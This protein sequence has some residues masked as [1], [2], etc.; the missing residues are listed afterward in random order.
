MANWSVESCSVC[1]DECIAFSAVSGTHYRHKSSAPSKWHWARG[2][3]VPVYLPG[4]VLPTSKVL[5]VVEGETD[6]HALHAVGYRVVSVLG[7]NQ[8]AKAFSWLA[9]AAQFDAPIEEIVV[10]VEP[11]VGGKRFADAARSECAERGIRLRL[12][13]FS[14]DAPDFRDL[15]HQVAAANRIRLADDGYDGALSHL[16]FCDA[17]AADDERLSVVR[18]KFRT[19]VDDLARDAI[20]AGGHSVRVVEAA[21]DIA[22]F[23]EL[24]IPAGWR[25][26]KRLGVEI[27]AGDHGWKR[28]FPVPL[29]I[30]AIEVDMHDMS[31]RLS[32]MWHA[33]GRDHFVSAP[34][35]V[36]ANARK[37]VDLAAKGLPVTS[38]NARWVV[39]WL[40]ELE[41]QNLSTIMRVP[42]A[43]RA[44]WIRGQHM[45]RADDLVLDSD[46]G[47]GRLLSGLVVAGTGDEQDAFMRI[48]LE[49]H[50]L[51]ATMVAASLAAPLLLP[52]GLRGFALHLWGDSQGGKTAA[53]KI[54]LSVWGDPLRLMGSW[55]ATSNAIEAHAATMC[56]LP[57][58]LDELQ[59]AKNRD[60][61]AQ[62][63]YALAN[64]VGR[65]RATVTG[66]LGTQ[67]SWRTV[68]M[69]TGEEPLLPDDANDGA[70]TRTFDLNA[71]PFT[72]ESAGV[73]AAH[74]HDVAERAYGHVGRAFMS[75]S[76]LHPVNWNGLRED[77]E[78]AVAALRELV[79]DRIA[80]IKLRSAGALVIT[81]NWL[82]EHVGVETEP[83]AAVNTIAGV[84]RMAADQAADD[85][86]AASMAWKTAQGV[87]TILAEFERELRPDSPT[88]MLGIIDS[89]GTI[90]MPE[91][92]YLTVRG[93]KRA[94]AVHGVPYKRGIQLLYE[95]GCMPSPNAATKRWRGSQ[96]PPSRVFEV[97]VSA[98]ELVER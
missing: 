30:D 62:T 80:P 87:L 89:E 96:N 25:L 77:H 90:G 19:R 51:A 24:E 52:L 29:V 34:R 32:L 22:V 9:D 94:C 59:S 64:G 41:H 11:G 40:H 54:A 92:A 53:A 36:V 47:T 26:T 49:R 3:M 61:I 60:H 15:L 12:A 88:G 7:A 73:D 78:S 16:R 18:D 23:D 91:R 79:G 95:S 45:H 57:T 2:G 81:L 93:M 44:G 31:E 42:V 98:C 17:L 85:D 83:G 20:Y 38:D 1:G 72:G 14:L 63:I 68:V 67:R 66:D 48:V 70:R 97:D 55:S 65:A 35:D 4:R 74:A 71:L 82:C 8:V 76:R 21:T 6:A 58:Y 86:A 39:R 33:L 13:S 56:D 75:W 43:R 27:D 84:L 46:T 28:L 5:H 50:P 69:T 37:I 10:W